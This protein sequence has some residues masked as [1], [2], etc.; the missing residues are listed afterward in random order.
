MSDDDKSWKLVYGESGEV[1][2]RVRKGSGFRL[3]PPGAVQGDPN[4]PNAPEVRLLRAIF[5]EMWDAKGG[6]QG[7]GAWV[8][9]PKDGDQ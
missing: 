5:G 8:K 3:P 6:E 2:G 7:Q 9:I 4:D 1:I